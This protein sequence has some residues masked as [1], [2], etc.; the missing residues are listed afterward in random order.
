[1]GR[2]PR[3][4]T[5]QGHRGSEPVVRPLG[6]GSTMLP[7]NRLDPTGEAPAGQPAPFG[8]DVIRDL[9]VTEV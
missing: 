4:G 5:R 8:P 3:V 6:Y 1:M 2:C 7:N 9:T